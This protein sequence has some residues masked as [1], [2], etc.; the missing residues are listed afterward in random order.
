MMDVYKVN[1][2]ILNQ[3]SIFIN[4]KFQLLKELITFLV[5]N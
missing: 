5:L 3:I 4:S 2:F 1:Y